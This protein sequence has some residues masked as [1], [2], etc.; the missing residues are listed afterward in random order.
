[1]LSWPVFMKF[2]RTLDQRNTLVFSLIIRW[3]WKPFRLSKQRLN[4]YDIAERH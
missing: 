1:M 4:I 2:K 3:L